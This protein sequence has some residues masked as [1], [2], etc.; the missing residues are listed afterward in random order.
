MLTAIILTFISLIYLR[1]KLLESAD[2]VDQ[3]AWTPSDFA[4]L[5][6]CPGFNEDCDY[7]VGSITE[8]IKK[9]MRV[10]HGI[11]EI[12]YVN[13]A[14]DIENIYELFAKEQQH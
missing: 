13:V 7:S 10:K 8:Q 2:L 9:H 4:L 6:H 11:M 5:G 12:E 3:M 14:Y 1:K